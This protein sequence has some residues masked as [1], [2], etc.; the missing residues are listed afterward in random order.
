MAEQV[1]SLAPSAG[2][3]DPETEQLIEEQRKLND[4]PQTAATMNDGPMAVLGADLSVIKA[5]IRDLRTEAETAAEAFRPEIDVHTEALAQRF[6]VR[7]EEAYRYFFADTFH[8]LGFSVYSRARTLEEVMNYGDTIEAL[9]QFLTALEVPQPVLKISSRETTDRYVVHGF[10]TP[11]T[12]LTKS[13]VAARA[14]N[15]S[16]HMDDLYLGHPISQ[17][18]AEGTN[19]EV[20]DPS[21]KVYLNWGVRRHVDTVLLSTQ[22]GIVES[23]HGFSARDRF[24]AVGSLAVDVA[25]SMIEGDEQSRL[26]VDLSQIRQ[27]LLG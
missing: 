15:S 21:L 26:E 24:I 9:G 23:S 13:P 12:G 16:V 7:R 17:P 25:L 20:R 11:K 19:R 8:R 3:L 10:T 1:F 2:T 14:T 18:F 6:H 5:R 22:D 27:D 4:A